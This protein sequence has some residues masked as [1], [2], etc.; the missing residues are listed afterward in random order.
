MKDMPKSVESWY[1][2]WIGA[3]SES[4]HPS[5]WERFYMFVSVLLRTSRKVRTRNW[6]AKNLREDCKKLSAEQIEN[7]CGKSG[8]RIRN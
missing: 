3:F 5:D 7:Y 6:L 4:R 8:D 1:R 2:R